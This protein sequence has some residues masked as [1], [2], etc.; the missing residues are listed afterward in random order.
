VYTLETAEMYDPADPGKRLGLAHVILIY[1]YEGAY[2]GV[3][4]LEP[5]LNPVNIAAF[6]SGDIL[7]VS[8]DKMNQTTR[9]LI[10]DPAGRPIKELKLFDEDY[11]LKLQLADKA[12]TADSV[13]R[14][15]ALWSH[16]AL[17]H[18]APFGENLLMSSNEAQPPLIEIN[19]NGVV[20]STNVIL[21]DNA[22]IGGIF[23]SSDRIYHVLASA[24]EVNQSQTSANASPPGQTFFVPTEIDDIYPSDGTIL[25]RV[26][27][28]RGL[29]PACVRDE[30]YTFVWT[31]GDDGKL[32]TIRG[33]VAH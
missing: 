26:K 29:M 21:P 30:S 32:Q 16:L 22:T 12:G 7:V 13:D 20:R 27:F 14:L 6:S 11:A 33:T 19:E 15:N 18:W 4:R 8:L 24:T 9:L 25:K 31:R 17:T 23:E 2:Q 1:D 10:F 5:G 28:T 3:V